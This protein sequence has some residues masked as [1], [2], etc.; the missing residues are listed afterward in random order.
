MGIGLVRHLMEH[1]FTRERSYVDISVIHDNHQ[2]ISLYEKL[3]CQR[4]PVF[5]IKRKNTINEHLFVPDPP[6]EQLNPYARIFVD[7]A[8]RRGIEVR[9][10]NEAFGIFQLMLGGKAVTCRES[11]S[12]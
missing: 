11:L 7:K 5:Y 2:A 4:I 10:V 6:G 12:D 3:G 1:Y 8:R 9:V